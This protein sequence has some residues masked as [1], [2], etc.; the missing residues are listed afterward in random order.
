MNLAFTSRNKS[1]PMCLIKNSALQLIMNILCPA[2]AVAQGSLTVFILL[3]LAVLY[4]IYS[5][6]FTRQCLVCRM[7]FAFLSFVYKTAF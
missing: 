4:T 3:I 7:N 2:Q 5:F 6:T 1:Y